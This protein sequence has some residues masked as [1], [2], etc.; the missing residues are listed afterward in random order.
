MTLCSKKLLVFALQSV[1]SFAKKY[2]I[3]EMMNNTII[4]SNDVF[5]ENIR[6]ITDIPIPKNIVKYVESFCV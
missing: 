5:K 1:C 2:K 4:N 3:T 6:D